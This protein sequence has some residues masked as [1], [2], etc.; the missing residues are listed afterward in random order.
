[1]YMYNV[2][3]MYHVQNVHDMY[4]YHA[5]HI[6]IVLCNIFISFS[7]F[8]FSS[9]PPPSLCQQRG[10][11]QPM[12]MAGLHQPRSVAVAAA[13]ADGSALAGWGRHRVFAGRGLW[14][15]VC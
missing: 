11:S 12:L 3:I 6:C 4:M 7:A 14:A 15:E 8:S 10:K 13:G 2:R 1:M 9:S 5:M